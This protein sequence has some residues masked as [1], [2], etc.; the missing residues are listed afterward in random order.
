MHVDRFLQGADEDFFKYSDCDED[1]TYDDL[2]TQGRD[3]EDSYFDSE[4][5]M[6]EIN[7]DGG[8]DEEGGGDRLASDMNVVDEKQLP[9]LGPDEYDY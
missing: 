8:A 1:D 9:P 6:Q 5:P 7:S 4:D 2:D 3:A